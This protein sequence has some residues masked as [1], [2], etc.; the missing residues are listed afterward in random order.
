MVACTEL[1]RMFEDEDAAS[2][3][4]HSRTDLPSK[5]YQKSDLGRSMEQA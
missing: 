5:Q 4:G 3:V 1:K 2:V